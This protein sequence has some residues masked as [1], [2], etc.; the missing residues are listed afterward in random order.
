LSD[1]RGHARI[2]RQ[3]RG[4]MRVRDGS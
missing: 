2:G 4:Y 1:G 3:E